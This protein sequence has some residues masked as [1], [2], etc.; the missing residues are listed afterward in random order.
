MRNVKD[1]Q[2]IKSRWATKDPKETVGADV[3]MVTKPPPDLDADREKEVA[4]AVDYLNRQLHKSVASVLGP[5]DV[6][7]V[8]TQKHEKAFQDCI[9]CV[10]WVCGCVLQRVWVCQTAMGEAHCVWQARSHSMGLAHR[11]VPSST[12]VCGGQG[13]EGGQ[14]KLVGAQGK[15][16]NGSVLAH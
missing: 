3:D 12:C 4:V 15:G 6:K 10:A 1:L 5:D 13:Y 16:A 14:R 7:V 2:V 9:R 8:W 11:A